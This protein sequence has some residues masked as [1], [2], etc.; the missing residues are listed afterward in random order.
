MTKNIPSEIIIGGLLNKVIVN[1]TFNSNDLGSYN[2]EQCEIYIKDR[3]CE[4]QK[5]ATLIHEILEAINIIYS[6]QLKHIQVELLETA[7]LSLDVKFY[8]DKKA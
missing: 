4:Q 7:L 3:Q 2:Y 5:R 8:F 6:V 1:D